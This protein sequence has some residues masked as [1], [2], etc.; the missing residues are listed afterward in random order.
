MAK[1]KSFSNAQEIIPLLGCLVSIKSL[2]LE[3]DELIEYIIDWFKDNQIEPE[4]LDGNIFITFG[5]QKGNRHLLFNAHMDVVPAVDWKNFHHPKHTNPYAPFI[6]NRRMYGRGAADTKAGL[7]AMM[8]LAKNLYTKKEI[9]NKLNG[10]VTFLFSRA[11]EA[12]TK[13][14][15]VRKVLESNK[16]PKPTAAVIAEPSNLEVLIGSGGLLNFSVTGF[17]EE[18][19]YLRKFKLNLDLLSQKAKIFKEH[20]PP[21]DRCVLAALLIYSELPK[22][23]SLNQIRCI[24]DEGGHSFRPRIA[25]LRYPHEYVTD[26]VLKLLDDLSS[27]LQTKNGIDFLNFESQSPA[28]TGH[29]GYATYDNSVMDS[30]KKL[31]NNRFLE[32]PGIFI[33][34]ANI[35]IFRAKIKTRS[36]K[37]K[38]DHIFDPLPNIEFTSFKIGAQEK[39]FSVSCRTSITVPNEVVKDFLSKSHN[40]VTIHSPDYRAAFITNTKQPI[41]KAALKSIQTLFKNTTPISIQLGASDGQIMRD[42]YPGLPVVLLSAGSGVKIKDGSKKEAPK[43]SSTSHKPDEFVDLRQAAILPTIYENI[44]LEYLNSNHEN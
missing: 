35:L 1:S 27:S 32:G 34:A 3:E 30:V 44:L 11:E 41:V 25:T 28:L 18:S 6:F 4:V 38:L 39:M 9:T 33:D 37:N 5:N 26:R 10:T 12:K 7:A 31:F 13:F 20:L 29:P 17:R 24:S 16:I 40:E 19:K 43:F 15:G 2:S 22:N 21:I 42:V 8:I 23:R 14:S 36:N